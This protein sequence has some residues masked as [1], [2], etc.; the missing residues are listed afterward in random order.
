MTR[1]RIKVMHNNGTAISRRLKMV[2]TI[3]N[4]TAVSHLARCNSSSREVAAKGTGGGENIPVHGTVKF[5]YQ[6][7]ITC[8]CRV[9]H[10][11]LAVAYTH[12]HNSN[13]GNSIVVP[14]KGAALVTTHLSKWCA[15]RRSNLACYNEILCNVRRSVREKR[16]EF[17]TCPKFRLTRFYN[18][19]TK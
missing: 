19:P 17:L 8:A 13:H 7:A 15:L 4:Q 1:I 5:N 14:Y 10:S 12:L 3:I 2:S 16:Q 18:V 6:L 11:R 9:T